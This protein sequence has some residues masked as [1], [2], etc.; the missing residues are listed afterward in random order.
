MSI[1][2]L[3]WL[4]TSQVWFDQR[5]VAV[6][7][8]LITFKSSK[9]TDIF[10]SRIRLFQHDLKSFK[11]AIFSAFMTLLSPWHE[12]KF[13]FNGIFFAEHVYLV[14]YKRYL[15]NFHTHC[16]NKSLWNEEQCDFFLDLNKTYCFH[17]LKIS[18]LGTNSISGG[19]GERFY[20]ENIF[21]FLTIVR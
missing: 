16:V 20:F 15:D 14:N 4:P 12:I 2:Y 19:C 11:S 17:Q 13:N 21:P 18:H 10:V 8:I 1:L 5:H 9:E 3:F 6:V 7:V